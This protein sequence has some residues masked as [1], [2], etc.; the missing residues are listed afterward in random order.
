MTL[1]TFEVDSEEFWDYVFSL[2]KEMKDEI[3]SQIPEDWNVSTHNVYIEKELLE[4]KQ[5]GK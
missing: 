2:P 1:K 3:I 4:I 5:N